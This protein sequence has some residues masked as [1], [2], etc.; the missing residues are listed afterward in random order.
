MNVFLVPN[1]GHLLILQNPKIVNACMIS[2]VGGEVQDKDMPSLMDLDETEELNGTWLFRAR[3]ISEE[4]LNSG[5]VGNHGIR[6][7]IH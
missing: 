6:K 5:G 3:E 7:E 4:N 2:I 1:A